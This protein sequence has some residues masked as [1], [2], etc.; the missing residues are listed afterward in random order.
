MYGGR[1][2]RNKRRKACQGLAHLDRAAALTGKVPAWG[3]DCCFSWTRGG[4]SKGR[5]SEGWLD[6]AEA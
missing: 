2:S 4:H 5:V 3:G 1:H 6:G